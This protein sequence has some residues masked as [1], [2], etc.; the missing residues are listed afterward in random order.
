MKKPGIKISK[1]KTFFTKKN[2]FDILTLRKIKKAFEVEN[3]S[4]YATCI[5]VMGKRDAGCD[6]PARVF[7]IIRQFVTILS[8]N[9][10]RD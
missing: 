8:L 9:K 4:P 1:T 7:F 3:A 2:I 6:A 10:T 5:Q